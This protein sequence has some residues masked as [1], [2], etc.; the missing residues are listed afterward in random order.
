MKRTA[1]LLFLM[2]VAPAASAVDFSSTE[3]FIPVVSRVPGVNETQWRSDLVISS[4][5][6]TD[7]VTTVAMM[8]TPAGATTP[9]LSTI[10]LQP[11][12][13]VTIHD[14]VGEHFGLEESFGT[15]SLVSTTPSVPIA[16]HARVY[17]VG[18]PAGQFGQMLQGIATDKLGRRLWLNGLTGINGNRTNMGVA[19][20][21]DVSAAVSLSWFD[22]NGEQRGGVQGLQV[23]PS[24]IYLINDVFAAFGIEYDEGLSV[25]VFAERPVYAYASVVR[26]DT[27]DAYTIIGNGTPIN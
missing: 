18:N 5:A 26:N 17:N 8:Y 23:P 22:K 4:R 2:V 19:N 20:P 15:L 9:L 13:T 3:V 1:L 12:Q 7:L 11:R 6:T 24:G 25:R 16:A 14:V 10:V 27:G 21:N